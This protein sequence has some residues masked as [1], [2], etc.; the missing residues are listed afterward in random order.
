MTHII[1]QCDTLNDI[2]TQCDTWNDILHNMTHASDKILGYLKYKLFNHNNFIALLLAYLGYRYCQHWKNTIGESE[3]WPS[4]TY[5]T[6]N[7]YSH[8]QCAI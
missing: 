7:A 4:F 8:Y 2:I 3:Y 5:Q 1:T 6:T